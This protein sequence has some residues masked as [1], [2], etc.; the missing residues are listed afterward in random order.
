MANIKSALGKGA[1]RYGELLSGSKT[2]RLGKELM[3]RGEIAN[4]SNE[5]VN[6]IRKAGVKGKN[7]ENYTNALRTQMKNKERLNRTGTK[8]V[9]EG[10]KSTG[11]RLGTAGAVGA[12]GYG[13]KKALGSKEKTAFEIVEESFD[14]MAANVTMMAD[15]PDHDAAL[16]KLGVKGTNKSIINKIKP[17]S[18]PK[19]EYLDGLVKNYKKNKRQITPKKNNLEVIKGLAKNKKL[20]VGAGIAALA[21]AGYGAAKALRGREEKA[22]SDIVEETFDKVASLNF[23]KSKNIGKALKNV[24]TGKNIRDAA[25]DLDVASKAGAFPDTIKKLK[26][27]KRKEIAKTIGLGIGTGAGV[28]ATGY[29]VNKALGKKEE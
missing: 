15:A 10:L 17:E 3:V 29:G 24:A 13:A 4:K 5:A 18:A 21:G 7:F 22:A 6:A 16:K 20:K 19:N 11:A 26:N 2:R 9:T 8:F 23:K 12:A 25:S 1:K 14:K 27:A 28:G